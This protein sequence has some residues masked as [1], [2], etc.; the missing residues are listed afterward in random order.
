MELTLD[1][2]GAKIYYTIPV[3]GGIPITE[4]VV[5]TW[6][7]MIL[8]TALCAFLTHNM[9]VKPQGKRQVIAEYLVQTAQNFVTGNMGPQFAYYTP[10]IAGLFALSMFSS[11]SGMTGAY[12]PT[13]DLSTLLAWALF[14]FVLITANKFKSNGF[15]GY[16]K[17]Y[18]EPIAVLTPFNIISEIATPVSMA[19]RHF[20]NIAS[21]SVIMGLVYAALAVLNY[22]VF[23][24]IPGAFGQALANIPILSIGVPAVLSLYFDIFSSCLQALIFCMLTMMYISSA[25]STDEA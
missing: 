12:A 4:T 10:F 25:A 3:L 7:I 16:F 17:G 13:S 24:W 2:N 21:G 1:V 18:T 19:F 23:H 11:L 9:K 14:V 8:L 22:A 6:V 15:L 20:G 5:N